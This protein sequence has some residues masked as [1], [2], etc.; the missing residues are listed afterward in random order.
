MSTNGVKQHK[1]DILKKNKEV[2]EKY[3]FYL[4]IIK[5][6]CPLSHADTVKVGWID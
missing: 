5:L 3:L 4:F 6:M 1:N 2:T